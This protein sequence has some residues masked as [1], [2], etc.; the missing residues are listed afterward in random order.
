MKPRRSTVVAVL[1]ATLAA[2]IASAY[3]N[4]PWDIY[5]MLIAAVGAAAFV[6]VT[7]VRFQ[8]SPHPEGN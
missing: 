1:A 8:A 2:A 4:P 7:V 5:S 6:L 3:I